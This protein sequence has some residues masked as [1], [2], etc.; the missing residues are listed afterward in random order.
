MAQASASGAY[1][2]GH[3][4]EEAEKVISSEQVERVLSPV[5]QRIRSG[6]FDHLYRGR[7]SS[8]LLPYLVAA[9]TMVAVLVVALVSRVDTVRQ[10]LGN[11]TIVE[12]IQ[13]VEVLQTGGPLGG[14]ALLEQIVPGFSYVIGGDIRNVELAI[15]DRQDGRLLGRAGMG[16]DNTYRFGAV[17]DGHYRALVLPPTGEETFQGVEIG[18]VV[19]VDGR[20]QLVLSEGLENFWEGVEIQIC[21]MGS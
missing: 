5:I 10:F 4:F 7:K 2:L 18:S 17:P 9:T 15:A 8:S 3:I 14:T 20:A 21:L 19:V 6:E 13:Y 11:V 1:A 16:D 12:T